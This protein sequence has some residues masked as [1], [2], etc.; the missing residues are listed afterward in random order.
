MI[1]SCLLTF[2]AALLAVTHAAAATDELKQEAIARL[3]ASHDPA[4]PVAIGRVY[5]KQAG[6]LAAERCS[7]NAAAQKDWDRSGP[8]APEWRAA[9][10]ELAQVIDFRHRP[11]HRGPGL[12]AC[13]MGGDQRPRSR[14]RGADFIAQHFS[15]KAVRNSGA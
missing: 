8:A 11:R 12:A 2:L 15:T 1:R 6:L 13:S 4:I 5:V 3:A 14:C 7:Q 9:E 10:A